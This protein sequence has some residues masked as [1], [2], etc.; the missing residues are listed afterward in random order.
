MQILHITMKF[1]N[2][3]KGNM[4]VYMADMF[5]GH[6]PFIIMIIWLIAGIVGSKL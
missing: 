5:T 4:E 1:Y 6:Y 2:L 3:I